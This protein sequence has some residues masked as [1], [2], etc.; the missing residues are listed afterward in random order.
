MNDRIQELAAEAK[1]SVPAGLEVDRWIE[2]YNEIFAK[3]IVR[4]CV[5]VCMSRAGNRDYNTGRLHCTSDI[6]QHFGIP[7]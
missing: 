1:K 7:E 6:K 5:A 3:L 4:E 2:C